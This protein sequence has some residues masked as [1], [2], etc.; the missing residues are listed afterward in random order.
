[1]REDILNKLKIELNEI[2][3]Y[4]QI[5]NEII[6]KIKNLEYNPLIKEYL[7]LINKNINNE[8]INNE[9]DED[10]IKRIYKKYLFYINKDETNKIFVY[11]GTYRYFDCYIKEQRVD[12]NYKRADYRIYCDIEQLNHLYLPIINCY[13]FESNNII[14]GTDTFFK[15]REF[16]KI[17][18]EF[19]IE[20]VKT[21]QESAKNKILNN[22]PLLIK[23]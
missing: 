16:S 4:N 20:S 2:K 15:E 19:F 10:I 21:N 14:I 6:K 22:Y 3:K 23:K 13:E 5:N 8:E 18:L 17:Q 9:K 12:Y 11:L 1:M 7:K